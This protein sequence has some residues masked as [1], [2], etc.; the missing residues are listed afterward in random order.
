M[1]TA[2]LPLQ[3]TFTTKKSRKRDQSEPMPDMCTLRLA[4][5]PAAMPIPKTSRHQFNT[6]ATSNHHTAMHNA[7]R[8]LYRALSTNFESAHAL[9]WTTM[10]ETWLARY[11]GPDAPFSAHHPGNSPDSSPPSSPDPPPAPPPVRGECA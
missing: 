6:A 4:N 3:S 1:S 5:N 10:R 7:S 11:N 8:D 9:W 2:S